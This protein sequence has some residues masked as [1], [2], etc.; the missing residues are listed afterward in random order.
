MASFDVYI[1]VSRRSNTHPTLYHNHTDDTPH[2]VIHYQHEDESFEE[3][4]ISSKRVQSKGNAQND[5]QT[6]G[7]CGVERSDRVNL[8]SGDDVLGFE[9][10]DGGDHCSQVCVQK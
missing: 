10:D 3:E 6:G 1:I 5:T 7:H 2:E 4:Y 8:F 9:F